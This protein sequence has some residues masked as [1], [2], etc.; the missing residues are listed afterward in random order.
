MALHQLTRIQK[1]PIPIDTAWDFFSDPGNLSLITPGYL[2][3]E[4][5]SELPS[6]IYEGEII[7]YRVRPLLGIPVTWI[8]EISHMARPNLFVD[9]QIS[10]PYKFWH[11]EHHFKEID[12]GIEMKDIVSYVMPFGFLGELIHPIIVRSRLDDIFNFRQTYLERRF[13]IYG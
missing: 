7:E 1:L 4:I 11:H 6:R 2:R 3:F 9:S 5:M 12:G 13:G 10:G 8:T